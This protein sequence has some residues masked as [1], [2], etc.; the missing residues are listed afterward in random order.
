LLKI[1][2]VFSCG[3]QKHKVATIF[4]GNWTAHSVLQMIKSFQKPAASFWRILSLRAGLHA[5]HE[6]VCSKVMI[7]MQDNAL[8][9]PSTLLLG[10]Q[11]GP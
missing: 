3:I 6:K 11:A 8:S 7:F 5:E 1:D 2:I 9:H 4:L 10:Q